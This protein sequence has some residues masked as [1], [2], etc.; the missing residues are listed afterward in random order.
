MAGINL[1]NNGFSGGIIATV[2]YPLL[3]AFVR[4]RRPVLQ[5]EDYFESFE[6]DE[7]ITPISSH[8]QIEEDN[9][10]QA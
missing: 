9:S 8:H 5:D 1:Y 2:L 7:P 6:H 3:M 4:H 10:K